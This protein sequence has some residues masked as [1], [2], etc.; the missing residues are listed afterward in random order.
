MRVQKYL[1]AAGL[2]SRRTA[3]KW[4]EEGRVKVN[5]VRAGLGMSVE[6]GDSV[7]V[8]GK[9]V[10]LPEEHTY[11]LLNKPRGYITSLFD[12]KGRPTVA[13][14]VKDVGKR[15]Y[16]VGRLDFD[17]EGLLLMTDDGETAQKLMHPS[18]EIEKTYHVQVVGR[19]IEGAA[20][21]L[22]TP[23]S[24]GETEFAPAATEILASKRRGEETVANL[25]V[26]I[27]EGKNRE[28]RRMCALCG[29]EVLRLRRVRQGEILLGDLPTGQWRYLTEDELQFLLNIPD[30]CRE[31]AEK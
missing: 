21:K 3:E 11:I 9:A 30:I 25:S 8:D 23:L 12:E 5:G 28:V 20:E 13:Q 29:L 4:I 19:D 1:S 10:L 31:N 26:T 6:T 18:H 22:R 24:D 27:H 2:C 15:V 7:T 14:L 16:P 17:S